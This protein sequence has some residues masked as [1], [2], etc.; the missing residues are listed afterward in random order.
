VKAAG[1][2]LASDLD[3]MHGLVGRLDRHANLHRFVSPESSSGLQRGPSDGSIGLRRLGVE[4]EFSMM[5][6]E[7]ESVGVSLR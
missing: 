4:P 3:R 5:F 2:G 7:G 1:L 6:D